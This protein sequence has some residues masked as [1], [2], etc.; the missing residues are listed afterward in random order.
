MRE[1]RA[2]DGNVPR[3]AQPSS[4]TAVSRLKGDL[5]VLVRARRRA[6]LAARDRDEVAQRLAEHAVALASSVFGTGVG[7]RVSAY[8]SWASEPPTQALIGALRAADLRI[9][10]SPRVRVRT[11]SRCEGR[12]E[13]GLSW[14]L[15]QWTA[16]S[17]PSM[18]MLVDA[19][20]ELALR[21]RA[22]QR[23]RQAWQIHSSS[24]MHLAANSIAH[25][26][27]LP[28]AWLS[29]QADGAQS[30]GGLWA[31]VLARAPAL[32]R[33]PVCTALDQLRR[34]LRC[35]GA[36]AAAVRS[37]TSSRYVAAD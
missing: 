27:A 2:Y 37:N 11:S 20:A 34:L 13:V 12:V 15:R 3:S 31:S 8:E 30:F 25:S 33:V 35:Q 9:R 5:R 29:R 26:M 28:A 4:S 21:L 22:R 16:A 6:G 36:A 23:L 7:G 1:A 24:A 17:G 18:S 19:P 14:Q 32:P 10:H